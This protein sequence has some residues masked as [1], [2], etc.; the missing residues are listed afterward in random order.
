LFG[1]QVVLPLHTRNSDHSTSSKPGLLA[2]LKSETRPQHQSVESRIDFQERIRD[3]ASYRGLLEVFL[4]FFEPLESAVRRVRGL[5][6]VLPDLQ[7]RMR[8]G[9]L[10]QDLVELGCSPAQLAEL[11]R[12]TELPVLTGLAQALGC[13]DVVEGSTLG[14]QILARELRPLGTEAERASSFFLSGG[15]DVGARWKRFADAAE[16]YAVRFP[17][18]TGEISRSAKRTFDCMENWIAVRSGVC[19][20]DAR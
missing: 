13:L 1:R 6:E 4:G 2:L 3:I 5:D 19:S 18:H 12:C 11:P 17:A 14:G 20:V 15:D 16:A 10:K 7:V 8:A 9:L